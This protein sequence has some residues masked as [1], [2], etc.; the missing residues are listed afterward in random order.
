MPEQ[1]AWRDADVKGSSHAQWNPAFLQ[2]RHLGHPAAR[3]DDR[4]EPAPG[5]RPVRRQRGRG[6]RADGPPLD[7][8]AVR[9]G[10]RHPGPGAARGRDPD[11]RPGRHLGAEWVRLQFATAK[12]GAILVNINP[13]YRSHELAFVLRQSQ[14]KLL[15]SAESF[16]TS[17]Y[18][19]MV[20]EV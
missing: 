15:V 6:G 5:G 10:H 1:A 9:R 19:A 14:V 7:L 2:S 8:P 3:R 4:G 13:A 16:K 17:D 12:I 18:R 11:R 20:G